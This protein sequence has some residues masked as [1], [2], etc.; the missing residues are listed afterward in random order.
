MPCVGAG[1]K[2]WSVTERMLEEW[3]PAYPALDLRQEV[4]RMRLWLL[5]HRERRKTA[6]GMP[7][8]ALAWLSRA[9]DTPRG[10][11]QTSPPRSTSRAT[12][13]DQ[14]FLDQLDAI[15]AGA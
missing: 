14:A 5:S 4:E 15:E 12:E 8:F 6:R 1:P 13:A 11:R 3:A 2:T 9:Q 10:S 7:R